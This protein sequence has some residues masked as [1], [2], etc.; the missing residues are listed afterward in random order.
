MWGVC[1]CVCVWGVRVWGVCVW[2][3]CVCVCGGVCV[4]VCV[5]VCVW[6]ECVCVCGVVIELT[7][8]SWYHDKR[9]QNATDFNRLHP[10]RGFSTIMKAQIIVHDV[11]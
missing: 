11:N 8:Y 5:C 9:I 6:C 3:V 1:V 4:C 7:Q 2:G 10:K